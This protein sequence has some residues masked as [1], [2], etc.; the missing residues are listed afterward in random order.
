MEEMLAPHTGHTREQVSTDIDRDKIPGPSG[1]DGTARRHRGRAL[2]VLDG[3][4]RTAR[5]TLP[6]ESVS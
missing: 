3:E 6:P 5:L 4:R 2:R 1:R